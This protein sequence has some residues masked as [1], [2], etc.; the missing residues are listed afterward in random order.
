MRGGDDARLE[1]DRA[2]MRRA[3]RLAVRGLGFVEPNPLVGCVI[4]DPVARRML[5]EGYHRRYG[6]A[7]AEVEALADVIRRGE[8]AAGATAYVTLEPC[9]HHGKTPPCVDALVAARIERCVIARPDPNPVAAGGAK[10]LRDAGVAVEFL[11]CPQA[12]RLTESFTKRMATGL[13]WVIVK[14][15]Q[16]LDGRIA[17]RTGESK[18]IS[19]PRSRAAVHR[20]RARADAIV[21][22][23][24]TVLADDPL[25]TARDVRRVPRR[26]RRVV[27]DPDLDIPLHSRLVQTARQAPLTL[28][29]A[30][31]ARTRQ[32]E[33]VAELESRG[34]DVLFLDESPRARNTASNRS[35]VALREALVLLVEMYGNTRVLVEAGG[36]LTGRLFQDGLVDQVIAYVA[37][38]IA[39]DAEAPSP[40][41]G[42]ALSMLGDA[43]RLMLQRVR[44]FGD[45][46]E[47]IYRVNRG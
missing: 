38:T 40:V 19:N 12:T 34:M 16:T 26:A 15:A 42:F 43:T 13:P 25:L 44:R 9:N 29:A 14:W 30:T 21:T 20:L 36:G 24:G 47:L 46:L 32:A 4:A 45:D 7:H 11:D 39:G 31:S 18:W 8:S 10:R 35:C 22:G 2:M 27:I 5:G 17:T 3:A 23:M 37:P 41:R 28:I 1:F 33:K 6:R